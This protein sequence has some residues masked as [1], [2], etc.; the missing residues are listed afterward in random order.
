MDIDQATLSGQEA[1]VPKEHDAP[2][3]SHREIMA[4]KL[5]EIRERNAAK[6][7][8]EPAP[9]KPEAKAD[10]P[11]DEKGKFAKQAD[12]PSAD[13]A[14]A[15]AAEPKQPDAAPVEKP[16]AAV[17]ID[18]SIQPPSSYTPEG[19]AAFL[20]ADP[21]IQKEILKRE[22]DFHRYYK[23]V[24]PLKQAAT[25]GQEI[26]KAIQPFEQ[27]IRSWGV[28]P[29]QAIQALFNADRKLTNGS[30]AEKLQAFA[31]LAKGYGIDLSQGLPA[32]A[33]VDPNVELLHRQNQQ[34]IQAAQAAQQRI[35]QLEAR[36]EQ[37]RKAAETAQ[38]N[39]VI[40]QAKQGKPHFDELRQEIGMILQSAINK[41]Q[42][43]TIDQ[44][45][46]AALWQSPQHR[47]ELLAKQQADAEAAA[48]RQRAEEAEKAKAA[49][50]ASSVNVQK[51]GTL[52]PQKPVG[53]IKDFMRE[54]LAEIK[55]R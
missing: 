42:P 16:A 28:P 34:A 11:R 33:S 35:Q 24:E 6:E 15:A 37:E 51:R 46:E 50:Q 44:A 1:E 25:F 7:P 52:Q 48:A 10:K 40:E 55:S 8:S 18:P 9:V 2:E 39:S 19:K 32:A 3:L 30:P 38:L 29:A 47:A 23:E 22:S 36:Y 31:D 21:Q 4:E 45:Y 26:Y 54:K 13:A 12:T 20:K 14:P 27:T 53:E 49:R 41:G 43:I 17:T 5:A